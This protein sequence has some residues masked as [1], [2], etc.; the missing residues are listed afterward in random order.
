MPPS[1][2]ARDLLRAASALVL[3]AACQ[4]EAA[5]PDPQLVAQWMRSSLA[6]VRSERLGPPVASRIS[7]Y[8]SLALFEGY[9]SDRVRDCARSRDS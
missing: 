9:A 7:A 6:S 5:A 4:R 1:L 8:A 3:L 2:R